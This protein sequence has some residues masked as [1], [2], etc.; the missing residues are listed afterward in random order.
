MKSRWQA[1]AAAAL[2]GLLAG[3]AAVGLGPEWDVGGLVL[4]NQ[5]DAEM[6]D[7]RVTV[8]RTGATVSCAVVPARGE[9]ST[10]FPE[11]RYRGNPAVVVWVHRGRNWS[12]GSF[13]LAPPE[14]GDPAQ[15]ATVLIVLGEGGALTVQ[16]SR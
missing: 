7:V 14:R 4:R 9:C 5:T 10:T 3:C 16:A 1:L 12:S 15:P 11:R 8:P 6:R 2:A 13:T